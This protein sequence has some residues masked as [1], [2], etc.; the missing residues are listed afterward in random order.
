MFYKNVV[1]ID[2]KKHADLKLS[3]AG[4]FKFAAEAHAIPLVGGE[5]PTA[6]LEYP[7]VFAQTGEKSFAATAMVGLKNGQNLFVSADGKWDAKYIPFFAR[8]YPF[9]TVEVE[10]DDAVICIE[11]TAIADVRREE[12]PN[13]FDGEVASEPMKEFA[14]LMFQ[15]RNDARSTSTFIDELA[16]LDVLR[17]VSANAD[18]PNGQKISMD[19]MWVVDDEKL[20]ALPIEVTGPWIQDGRMSLVYAHL[21]SLTNLQNLVD[22]LQKKVA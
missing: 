1:A 11:E 21:F 19:G 18:L 16:K 6:M 12:D 14:Q 22:K 10:P 15:S 9:V 2:P 4:N 13:V 8:R 7:I 20:R 17:Q 5:F 3:L